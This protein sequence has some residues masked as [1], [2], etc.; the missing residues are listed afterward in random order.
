M[1]QTLIILK[2]TQGKDP[3]H[4]PSA[5]GRQLKP[6]PPVSG[7]QLEAYQT[8]DGRQSEPLYNWSMSKI[9]Q[10]FAF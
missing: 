3:D 2:F 10:G 9:N 5:S 7:Q 1:L 8:A 6:L 4:R